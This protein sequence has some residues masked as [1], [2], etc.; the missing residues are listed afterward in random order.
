RKNDYAFDDILTIIS[1]KIKKELNKAILLEKFQFYVS[2]QQNIILR[3]IPLFI[4]DILLKSIGTIVSE[5][6]ATT[7][8]SNLGIVSIADEI[9]PY[10]DKFDVIAYHDIY[11]PFKVGISSF[12]DK[13]SISF[14][15][16]LVD[17]EIQRSF[18]TFLSK[19]GIDIRITSSTR[20]SNDGGAKDE[21]L[22]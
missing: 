6:G 3:V 5:H 11:L 8:L 21:V 2:L 4:K 16:I 18:F 19:K 17:T 10:I 13:L 9:K 7:T 20:E 15:S 14:S 1:N 12:D 22:Q